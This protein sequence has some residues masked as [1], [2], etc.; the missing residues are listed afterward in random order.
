MTGFGRF[1]KIRG[2]NRGLE[3]L[4]RIKDPRLLPYG[5]YHAGKSS[6]LFD[7]DYPP[8]V[9]VAGQW[10]DCD[11]KS[12]VTCNPEWRIAHDS[13]FYFYRDGPTSPRRN[14]KV[15][16]FLKNLVES[17]PVLG[18]EIQRRGRAA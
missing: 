1:V 15:R 7:R 3:N 4:S 17:I 8:L 10:P 13:R 6:I 2:S 9:C 12:A 16:D 18:I 5:V 14:K 11:T